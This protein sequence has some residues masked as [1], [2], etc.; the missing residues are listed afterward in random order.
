MTAVALDVISEGEGRLP[1]HLRATVRQ[2]RADG[3]NVGVSGNGM[4]FAVAVLVEPPV[5]AVKPVVPNWRRLARRPEP[6]PD[7]V[8]FRADRVH[9]GIVNAYGRVDEWG[10]GVGGFHRALSVT[11]GT[12][13]RQVVGFIR[14]PGEELWKFLRDNGDLAIK[15]HYALWARAY[16]QTDA[17][18][19]KWVKQ[20]V[21][22]FCSD[23][24][25]TKQ[26]AGGYKSRDKHQAMRL[27]D[28]LTTTELAVE[29]RLGG[30]VIRLRGSIWARGVVGEQ[31][32]EYGDL[33]GRVRVGDRDLWDPVGFS[34]RPGQWF[35]DEDW[36]LHNPF[37]GMVGVGL[38]SIGSR[39]KWPLRIGA[40]YGTLARL[41]GYAQRTVRVA[42]VLAR[43]GLLKLDAGHPGKQQAAFERAHDH[44][45]KVGVLAGWEFDTEPVTDEPDVDE[46]YADYGAGDWRDQAV[47]LTWP[48]KLAPE[49][50][51][52]HTAK[53]R[54]ITAA[55]R[56]RDQRG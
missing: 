3:H 43:T 25:Y 40:Y 18:P 10:D 6:L 36:R 27:L 15:A 19:H 28:A 30:N 5:E 31:R 52:L 54:K 49:A 35:D 41:G 21:A 20:D 55:T 50:E 34:Y 4:L 12:S 51:R 37:I 11:E 32:D 39:D 29:T 47:R 33:F 14:D 44:L 8:L 24:G 7:V 56:R 23:L 13:Y 2:L 42:T 16:E 1:E 17:D 45:V 48:D 22:Q 38:L 46:D 53:Q 26:K 9:A